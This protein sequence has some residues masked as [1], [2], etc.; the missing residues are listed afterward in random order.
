VLND[1]DHSYY[2]T[3][4]KADGVAAQQAWAWKTFANGAGPMFMD[5]YLEVWGGRNAPSGTNVDRYWDT[6]RNALGRTRMYADR[7]DLAH[8]TPQGSL[9]S[10]GYCLAAPG[11]QY[12]VYQPSSG[13]FTLTM[14]AGTYAFEW[15]DPTAGTIAA[16]GSVDVGDGD[17]TFTPPFSGDAVLLLVH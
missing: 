12:L 15:Y 6:L 7:M 11:A 3:V 14:A 9:S 13:A 16:T 2:W 5:P 17:H 1:T 10:T 8:A 4:L